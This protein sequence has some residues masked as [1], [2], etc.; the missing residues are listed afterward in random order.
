MD[1]YVW[2]FE[3]LK[4]ATEIKQCDLSSKLLILLHAVPSLL[5]IA[6]QKLTLSGVGSFRQSLL[7][8]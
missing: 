3:R 5:F 8:W 2:N 1:V 6:L 7:C 4:S